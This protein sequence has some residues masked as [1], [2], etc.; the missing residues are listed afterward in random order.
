MLLTY[1]APL[2]LSA[3][4]E[5]DHSVRAPVHA[6]YLDDIVDRLSLGLRV[7]LVGQPQMGREVQ[8][9]PHSEILVEDVFLQHVGYS[10][11]H[12]LLER[13]VIDQHLIYTQRH[14]HRYLQCCHKER[15]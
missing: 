6:Q 11:P 9:L 2:L 4:Y 13:D 10:S 1:V 3:G 7:H 15:I 12:G 5:H 14:N 8:L